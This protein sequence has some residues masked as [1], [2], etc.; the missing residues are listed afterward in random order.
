[1]SN[2]SIK[3]MFV[4]LE[5]HVTQDTQRVICFKIIEKN[6]VAMQVANN[7]KVIKDSQIFIIFIFLLTREWGHSCKG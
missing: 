1:M 4:N 2:P 5:V 6:E 3:Q 7:V